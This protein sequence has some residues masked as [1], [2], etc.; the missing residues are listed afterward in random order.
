MGDRLKVEFLRGQAHECRMRA[1][2]TDQ[3]EAKQRWLDLAR[4]YE[5]Q[6]DHIEATGPPARSV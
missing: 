1:A 4:E 5:R 2:M 6:A 3:H